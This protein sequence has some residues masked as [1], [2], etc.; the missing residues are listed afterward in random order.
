MNKILTAPTW[1]VFSFLLIC[2]FS[3]SFGFV[4]F[5]V[6]S[7]ILTYCVF[8]LAKNIY[9]KLPIDHGLNIRRFNFHLFAIIVCFNIM[10]IL[11][12]GDFLTNIKQYTLLVPIELF[13]CYSWLYVNWFIAK[14]IATVEKKGTVG[15]HEYSRDFFLLWLPFLGIWW[16]HPKVRKIFLGQQK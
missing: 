12:Y 16:V 14:S 11:L 13:L 6:L 7:A 9:K 4:A 3:L 15:F 1:Q 8:F 2:W 5:F 10:M